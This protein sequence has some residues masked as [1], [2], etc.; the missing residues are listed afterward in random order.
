MTFV[1]RPGGAASATLELPQAV[2]GVMIGW[3]LW[4]RARA[5]RAATPADERA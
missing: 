5:A 1:P 2:S 4:R 3:Y